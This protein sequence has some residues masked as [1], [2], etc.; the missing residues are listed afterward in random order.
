[1]SAQEHGSA[2]NRQV[3]ELLDAFLASQE[4]ERN[5]STHSVRAYACDLRAF[6]DWAVREGVDPLATGHRNIRR[7]LAYLDQAQYSRR[8]VNRHLSALRGFY[9]FLVAEEVLSA[10]PLE[11]VA[12]PKQPKSLPRLIPPAEMDA[13]LNASDT[14]TVKGLRDQ[15]ILETLYASGARIGEV[16]TLSCGDIDFTSGHMRV[17]GKGSKERIVPLH[18]L[19]IETLHR[20]L[21]ESRPQLAGPRSGDALFLSTRGNP[22]SAEALRNTFKNILARAGVD[23]SY[24]PHDVR[25]TFA[26][27]LL[28]GGADLRSVQEMLGHASL[29]TT[30]IY[31]HLSASH[32]K[33]I[34]HQ[35]HPRA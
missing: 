13:I 19:A 10:S 9:R 30:Q 5:L 21:R 29:S 20:Y 1:M 8:T 16:A 7:Y 34:H 12:G 11:A 26:T 17:L 25:H 32:L 15:A 18:P 2:S 27:D 28:E 35:S 6:L 4:I 3:D 33:D 14:G 24:H 23:Q 31:T 22:M